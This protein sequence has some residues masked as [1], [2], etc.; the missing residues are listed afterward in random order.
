MSIRHYHRTRSV[1]IALVSAV[2]LTGVSTSVAA[3]DPR[4][5][6][7]DPCSTTLARAAIWPGTMYVG[8]AEVRLVSDAFDSYL[9]RQSPCSPDHSRL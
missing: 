2:V 3:A 6:D 4:A 5:L 1:T 7:R 9:S 8:D